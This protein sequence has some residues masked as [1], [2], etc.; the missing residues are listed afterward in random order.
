MFENAVK[1][2]GESTH[3][4]ISI[5][6]K[7]RFPA[8]MDRYWFRNDRKRPPAGGTQVDIC[9]GDIGG[10]RWYPCRRV[11]ARDSPG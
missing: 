11:S 8:V 9:A 10:T 7:P 2:I 3:R 4:L 1:L 6:A 5:R